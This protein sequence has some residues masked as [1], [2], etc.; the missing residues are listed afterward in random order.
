VV[1]RHAHRRLRACH[2]TLEATPIEDSGRATQL[3]LGY[4]YRG[5]K[6]LELTKVV[7]FA[8]T[9]ATE[10]TR[11]PAA[12]RCSA[13]FDKRILR[14]ILRPDSSKEAISYQNSRD[15]AALLGSAA[16]NFDSPI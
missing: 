1:D 5:G 15:P 12:P 3:P 7:F 8:A 9:T 2:P 10:S 4:T 11:T 6:R 14:A 13:R 16:A